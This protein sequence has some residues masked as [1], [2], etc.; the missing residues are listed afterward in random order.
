[1]ILATL[2]R[3][4]QQRFW[5]LLAIATSVAC[6]WLWR[7][8]TQLAAQLASWRAAQVRSNVA[9][10]QRSVASQSAAGG[11]DKKSD[12]ATLAN[13][14]A[15]PSAITDILKN[16]VV[17]SLGTV[18]HLGAQTAE[19]FSAE[20]ARRLKKQAALLQAG[21]PLTPEEELTGQRQ[22]AQLLGILPEVANFQ[23][24]PTEYG[25]FF[26]SLLE[27]GAGLT[28]EQGAA[29]QALMQ[30]RAQQGIE[31]GLNE[32]VKP[33]GAAFLPWEMKRDGF[34]EDTA[35]ALNKILPEEAKMLFPINGEFLE[36]LESDF[37]K[38]G[39]LAPQMAKP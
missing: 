18:E 38:A 14:T 15:L 7:E 39:Q 4:I 16:E 2:A 33:T 12:S 22:Y 36:F 29:V 30:Q 6:F 23:N 19:F 31:L 5:I 20:Q 11:P 26:R 17:V 24:Q 13:S 3:A 32:A 10:Q 34:N 21:E 35:E 1:M 37:D 27:T 25:R 9:A 28:K 8:N